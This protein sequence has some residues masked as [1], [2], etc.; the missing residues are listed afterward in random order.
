MTCPSNQ[1]R[2]QLEVKVEAQ[3]VGLGLDPLYEVDRIVYRRESIGHY[4]PDYRI[5]T[6]HGPLFIEVKGR[7]TAADRQK[8]LAILASNPSIRLF[9]ALQR[10]SMLISKASTTTYAAWANKNG[11]PWCPIPIPGDFLNR[12]INGETLTCHLENV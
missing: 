2:S 8:M 5:N 10:P 3:L 1:R 11:V 9:V 6:D 12:W 4:R 7:W